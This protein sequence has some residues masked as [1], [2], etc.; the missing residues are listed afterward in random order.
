MAILNL[1]FT[2]T[3]LLNETKPLKL[4]LLNATVP[5][6]VPLPKKLTVPSPAINAPL[7]LNI[8]VDANVSEDALD[9]VSVPEVMV[10]FLQFAA[11]VPL[12]PISGELVADTIT[13]SVDEF[14]TALQLQL[15]ATF[16]SLLV[17][18]VHVFVALT[19]MVASALEAVHGEL[20][21]VHLIKYDPVPLAGVNTAVGLLKLLN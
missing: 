11:V 7:L 2:V 8:E 18:P 15:E 6:I 5:V 4:M 9:I 14:G 21:I 16:Q 1:L 10:K 20:L 17:A 13:A 12:K 3:A 19:V